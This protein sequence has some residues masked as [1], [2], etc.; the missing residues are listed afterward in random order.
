MFENLNNLSKLVRGA[1]QVMPRV[2]ALKE[3]LA[4]SK[5]EVSSDC[6][7][8]RVILTG[9]GKIT[10]LDIEPDFLEQTEHSSIQLEIA[11]TINRALQQA[12][13]LHLAAV[14]EVVGDLGIPG[15]DKILTQLAD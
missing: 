13:Q 4:A 1:T 10:A 14:K 8:I 5:I 9:E 2:R 11:S 6:K 3:Q 7:S 15:I 12:K